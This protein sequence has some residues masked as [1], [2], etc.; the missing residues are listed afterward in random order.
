M[1]EQKNC[2]WSVYLWCQ[3]TNASNT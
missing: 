1:V 2:S 3:S